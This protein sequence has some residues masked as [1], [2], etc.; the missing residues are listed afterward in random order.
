MSEADAI[1]IANMPMDISKDEILYLFETM[2]DNTVINIV[3]ESGWS[4][5]HVHNTLNKKYGKV[6]VI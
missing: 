5:Y 2:L 6:R 3:K 1:R 4:F